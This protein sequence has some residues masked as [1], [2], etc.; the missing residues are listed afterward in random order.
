VLLL[1]TETQRV[2]GM[3]RMMGLNTLPEGLK[4]V[5]GECLNDD[6]RS[7]VE[8][9][10]IQHKDPAIAPESTSATSSAL[11][12]GPHQTHGC[13]RKATFAHLASSSGT[14]CEL[15]DSD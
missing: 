10:T 1:Y 14:V 11:V 2:P 6:I 9:Q 3:L 8:D 12:A 5:H 15:S 7:D 4:R 13:N